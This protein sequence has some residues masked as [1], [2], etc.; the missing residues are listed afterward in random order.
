MSEGCNG[1]A[2]NVTGM[3]LLLASNDTADF[4]VTAGVLFG[5]GIC[6]TE[7]LWFLLKCTLLIYCILLS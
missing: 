7:S 3:H 2:V 5:R 4:I 1:T 6:C